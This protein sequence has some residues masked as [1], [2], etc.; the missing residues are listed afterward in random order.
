MQCHFKSLF[1]S[2]D[3]LLI[4]SPSAAAGLGDLHLV[5]LSQG[6][7]CLNVRDETR[8]NPVC[9]SLGKRRKAHVVSMIPLELTYAQEIL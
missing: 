8:A 7:S 2:N 4:F 9:R 1:R 5:A 6:R 3:S